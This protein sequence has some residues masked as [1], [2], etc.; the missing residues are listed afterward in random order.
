MHRAEKNRRWGSDK[1]HETGHLVRGEMSGVG[2]DG[3]PLLNNVR[4]VGDSIDHRHL[5]IPG[6][7]PTGWPAIPRTRTTSRRRSTRCGTKQ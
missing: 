3:E 5:F 1:P 7:Q 2:Y 4:R 6:A